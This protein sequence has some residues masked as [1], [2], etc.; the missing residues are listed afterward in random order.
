[1]LPGPYVVRNGPMKGQEQQAEGQTGEFNRHREPILAAA[2][3]GSQSGEALNPRVTISLAP[4]HSDIQ[5][6]L[7]LE[8]IE[9]ELTRL[10]AEVAALPRRV[11]EIE[12]KL[13][14]VRAD[15]ERARKALKDIE[16]ARRQREADIQNLQQKISKYRDQMLSVKTNHEYKALGSEINFAEQET[17]LIEDK[18]LEGM[19]ETEVRERD[20]R[21]AEAAQ[22]LQQAEVEKEKYLARQRTDEDQK[23]MAELSPQRDA[24]R[25][26]V[27][28]D[29]LHHYDRVFKLRGS[30]LAEARDQMCLACHVQLR[31]QVFLDIT[32]TDEVLTCDSCSRILYFNPANAAPAESESPNRKEAVEIASAET[33]T[34]TEHGKRRCASPAKEVSE[35]EPMMKMRGASGLATQNG[36][37]VV[38]S[39]RG[40]ARV[41]S[42]HPWVYRSDIVSTEGVAPGT[43]VPVTDT[44]GNPLGAAFYSSASQIA[45]RMLGDLPAGEEFSAVLEQRIARAVE[46]RT[47]VVR[48]AN[49]YRV[50]FGEADFLPGLVVDRYNDVLSLQVLTQATDSVGTREAV[51]GALVRHFAPSGIVERVDERVRKLENLPARETGLLH[52]TKSETEFCMNGI[53]FRYGGLSGQKTGAFLDQRENYAAAA[54]YAGG[55]ALDVFCYQGGFALHLAPVCEQVTGIDSS[56][57]ALEAAEQ[58]AA[59]NG[60]EVEWI[61]ANAFDLLKDY[62]AA[63]RQFD[64]LVLDPPAFAKTKQAVATALR[65]YKELNLRALKML[66]GNGLLVT[67]SCSFHVSETEFLQMLASAALDAHKQLRVLERRTQAADHPILLTVPETQYLKCILALVS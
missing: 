57:P 25:A 13:A 60:R 63:G 56:R 58:N 55:K 52:G 61:E 53:R 10:R 17:R 38:V 67:C 36:S 48:D 51:L 45:I 26:A 5:K 34:T 50:V 42:G 31:P 47:R 12:A 18:I 37:R 3:G 19:L 30:S 32:T 44:A 14:G 1:M 7:Q 46:F 35:R 9:R 49:A 11:G 66:R 6:L 41:H 15:M 8:E 54:R 29:L 23:H 16:V 20:L 4:M 22:K 65:G 39:V 33:P 2:L 27:N 43:L 62:A 21:T 59:L 40:A 24:L 28:P 64:T